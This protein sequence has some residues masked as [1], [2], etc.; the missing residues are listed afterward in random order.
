MRSRDSDGSDQSS[1]SVGSE[2]VLNRNDLLFEIVR[3]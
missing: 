3:V 2:R 1:W